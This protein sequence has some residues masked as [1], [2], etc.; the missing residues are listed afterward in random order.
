MFVLAELPNL[1][2]ACPT[3]KAKLTQPA[4][5]SHST[6]HA[7]AVAVLVLVL[8]SVFDEIVKPAFGP[9]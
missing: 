6:A 5:D 4:V 3:L 8:I 2:T 1:H 9:V 7:A